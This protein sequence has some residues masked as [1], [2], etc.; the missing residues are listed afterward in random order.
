MSISAHIAKRLVPCVLA[1]ACAAPAAVAGP[2]CDG[3]LSLDRVAERAVA[4]FAALDAD[5]NGSVT[6]A[7][8]DAA[9]SERRAAAQGARLSRRKGRHAPGRVFARMDADDNGALSAT[10]FHA[11]ASRMRERDADKDGQLSCA[12]RRR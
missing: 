12:E 11:G 5:D 2:R 1:A 9:V 10:E 3:P 6:R 7:E 4:R 8:F